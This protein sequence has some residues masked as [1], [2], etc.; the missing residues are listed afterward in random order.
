MLIKKVQTSCLLLKLCIKSDTIFLITTIT[1]CYCFLS[2]SPPTPHTQSQLANL[3][4]SQRDKITR[5]KDRAKDKCSLGFECD[6]FGFFL[7]LTCI[8][9]NNNNIN[10]INNNNIERKKG[11]VPEQLIALQNLTLFHHCCSLI[12]QGG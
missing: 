6:L 5:P 12:G 1:K 8:Y 11:K 7:P 2:L 3:I 9:I 4:H 10:N